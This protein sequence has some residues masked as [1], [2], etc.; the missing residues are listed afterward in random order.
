MDNKD[1]KR[2]EVID[3][4]L[5]EEF[6][7]E[8]LMDLVEQARQEAL[9]R[10]K[11][12]QLSNQSKRR[13]PKW[14]FWVIALAMMLQVIA[15]LPQ[16]LSIPAIDFLMTSAKLSTQEEIKQYKQAVVVIETDDSR[17]T[18]FAFT[19]DGF[20]LTNYHV[21]EGEDS[22]VVAFP[23]EGL[24]R[25]DVMNTYPSIDLAV[26][27]AEGTNFP[28]LPLAEKTVFAEREKVHVIGNPLRFQGIANE[29]EIIDYIKLKHWDEEV[30]M[31][32]APIY[33]GNS[34]SPII[35]DHGEVIG[36]VFA[37]LHHKEHG[38]VGLF[39][40]IDYFYKYQEE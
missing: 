1:H 30:I 9:E 27:K 33:R 38:R 22:V 15:L 21:I 18:G 34:G 5:Y 11:E 40:P 31:I 3:E 10:A 17:G 8:E 14:I 36:V 4:D 7:D 37:T 20:I 2:D 19:H 16:T 24:F 35:N 39:V 29:G 28:Y 13:F 26:L 32:Q 12:R 23:E 6:D 25:A